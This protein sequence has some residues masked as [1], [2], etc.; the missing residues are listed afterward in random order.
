MMDLWA[1]LGFNNEFVEI[2]DLKNQ[3]TFA[4]FPVWEN[5]KMVIENSKPKSQYFFLEAIVF[6]EFPFD[7][8]FE[9]AQVGLRN[10]SWIKVVHGF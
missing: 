4:Y 5:Q 2:S 3:M 10:W 9:V 1:L 6:S 7:N 8:C